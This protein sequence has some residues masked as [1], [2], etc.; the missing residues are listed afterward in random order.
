MIV[1]S[2]VF[3]LGT[4][5][6]IVGTII[7]MVISRVSDPCKKGDIPHI[8]I[9]V[10]IHN[11]KQVLK[12]Q[13]AGKIPDPF[14]LGTQSWGKRKIAS[15]V[16]NVVSDQKFTE[17]LAASVAAEAPA[18]LKREAGLNAN[19]E[20]LFVKNNYFVL[21]MLLHKID[22]ETFI[23]KKLSD[24]HK[25][26]LAKRVDWLFKN[27]VGFDGIFAEETKKRW[28]DERITELVCRKVQKGI[29]ASMQVT[30]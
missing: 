27:I 18:N 13:V 3:W 2:W 16:N 11:K 20:L 21:K 23:A 24:L 1:L 25:P 19:C 29:G 10:I 22:S 4:C 14:N 9:N 30:S 12:E 6:G 8:Y 17:K 28:L 26:T 7:A 5:L 15:L